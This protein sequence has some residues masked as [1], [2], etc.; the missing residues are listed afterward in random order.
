MISEEEF[1]EDQRVMRMFQKEQELARPSKSSQ[2]M[3]PKRTKMKVKNEFPPDD[4]G[5]DNGEGEDD[6]EGKFLSFI[7]S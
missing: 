5:E 3:R 6:L 4:E 2:K 7:D 1:L